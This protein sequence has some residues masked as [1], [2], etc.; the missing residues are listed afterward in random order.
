MSE[1]VCALQENY[2]TP[3]CEE[4]ALEAQPTYAV[5]W[6]R[7]AA[8]EALN[9]RRIELGLSLLELDEAAELAAGTAAK[10]LGPS[11]TKCLGMESFFRLAGALG[12]NI[13]L[14][15]N[16]KATAALLEQSQPRHAAQA[17]PNN[18]AQRCG[19]R[20]VQRSLHH[21]ART[22]P[23]SEILKMVG[24]ARATVAAAKANRKEAGT[25]SAIK[26]WEAKGISQRSWYRQR[27]AP[28]KPAGKIR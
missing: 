7:S 20:Y 14:E 10:Y 24:E 8:A 12:L 16:A 26:P 21:M 1:A 22:Y 6:N 25:I 4:H 19:P 27:R 23:W 28:S 9:E 11:Q 15:V 17:R 2:A 5:L 3:S 18:L 13:V